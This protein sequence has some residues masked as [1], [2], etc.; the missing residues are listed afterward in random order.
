MDKIWKR[1]SISNCKKQED[2]LVTKS[3]IIIT[4]N[5]ENL[6]QSWEESLVAPKFTIKN[7]VDELHYYIRIYIKK[8]KTYLKIFQFLFLNI[9][10]RILYTLGT[11]IIKRKN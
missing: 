5:D 11:F 1:N 2:D 9:V 7:L 3:Y 8:K 10:Q 4:I 6:Y